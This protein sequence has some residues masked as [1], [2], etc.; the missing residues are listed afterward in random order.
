MENKATLEFTSGYPQPFGATVKDGSINFAVFSK[1]ATDVTL[2]LFQEGNH[3]PAHELLLDPKN[4][5]TGDVW[6]IA[7]PT[8]DFFSKMTYAFR[9]NGQTNERNTFDSSK[10]L[11]D[12]YAKEVS[13]TTD[14][15]DGKPYFPLGVVINDDFNWENDTPPLIPPQDLIIYEMHV[16]SFTQSPT[17]EVT[18]KGK[19]LGIIEKI[20]YLLELGINAVELLP[21]HEFNEKDYD[22]LNPITKQKLC[23]YWGYSTMNFFSPMQRYATN[24]EN[25]TATR[26]FKTMVKELHKNGIEVILDVVF[27]HTGEGGKEGPLISFKGLETAVYFLID[28]DNNYLNY[29]GCGNTLNCNHPVMRE[30]II[31][32]LRYWVTEMHIDG[33]RFDLASIL[34][35]GSQGQPLDPSPLI[36]FISQDPILAKVKLIAEPWDAAGLYQVGAFYYQESRWSEWNGKYRDS[37][38]RFIKGTPNCKAEFVTRIC[39]SED[40]YKLRGPASS[41]NFVTAH[42]G[43]SLADLVCFNH[44]HNNANGEHNRDGLNENESWNCGVEGSTTN[45]KILKIREQQ[46][47][48]FF[49]ALMVSQGIPMILMGDEYGHTR[50]GNNNTWCHDNELNWFLW[51]Q[52][53]KYKGFH[54]F[55]SCIIKFRKQNECLHLNRFLTENDISWHGRDGGNGNWNEADRFISFTLKDPKQAS[56][57]FVAFNP[58]GDIVEVNFPKNSDNTDKKSWHW[59]VNTANDTPN[60][61]NEELS[62]ET[63]APEKYSMPPY[64]AIILKT[65]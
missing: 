20:P 27:N 40:L 56:D 59:I 43:F 23:N 39:G 11:L 29:S 2:C 13:T 54:R 42:D 25:G 1:N 9:V 28:K 18:H 49:L 7:I 61:F 21:I 26:E 38:R 63:L 58:S 10:F 15:N 57:L 34:T 37:V 17:S 24:S 47:R 8:P 60:D 14:W 51:D 12:P 36:D 52:I 30:L 22:K 5:K 16:R 41:L 48:N 46:M 4:N 45:P 50:R 19:F 53:N 64:S 62:N 33:F 31:S 3:S 44:K 65:S 6:H 55:C 35:R 32:S